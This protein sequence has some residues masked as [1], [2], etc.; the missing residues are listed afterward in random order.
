MHEIASSCQ[1][2]AMDWQWEMCGPRPAHTAQ[3]ESAG[4]RRERRGRA[5]A[6]DGVRYAYVHTAHDKP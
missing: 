6:Y 2:M 1:Q 3:H 5:G 4:A